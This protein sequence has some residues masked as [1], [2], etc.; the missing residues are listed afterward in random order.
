M[1]EPTTIVSQI[2]RSTGFYYFM[3]DGRLFDWVDRFNNVAKINSFMVIGESILADKIII[4][5][6]PYIINN[7]KYGNNLANQLAIEYAI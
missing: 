6:Q 1:P 5:Y 4:N 3:G 2:R 7:S